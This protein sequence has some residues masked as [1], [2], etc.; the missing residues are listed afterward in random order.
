VSAPYLVDDGSVM[1]Q[2]VRQGEG[3]ATMPSFMVKADL[4]AGV[5][6]RVLP[7]FKLSALEIWALLPA[8]RKAPPRARAF[9]ELLARQLG[10]RLPRVA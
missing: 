6:A 5:L 4:D 1:Q 7:T 2:L 8:G 9:V 10:P 3:I